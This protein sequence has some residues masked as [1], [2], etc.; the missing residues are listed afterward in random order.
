MK[1]DQKKLEILLRDVERKFGTSLRAPSDFV[2][3]ASEIHRTTGR[4]IGLSTLKRLWG[5][6]KDQ[7][8]TTYST[9]S[10]LCRY[11]GFNDW[12]SFCHTACMQTDGNESGFSTKAIVDS[13]TLAI[14]TKVGISMGEAKKCL[15]MKIAEPDR[16]QVMET[17]HIKLKAGDTLHITTIAIGRPFFATDCNRDGQRLGCY[18]GARN[19]GIREID[20]VDTGQKS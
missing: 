5:Y 7:N 16:F 4:T 13:R 15:L 19:E 6:I 18:T 12:D 20:I 2:I 11:V 9:L 3:L 17:Q 10:L 1:P 14:G 8:G